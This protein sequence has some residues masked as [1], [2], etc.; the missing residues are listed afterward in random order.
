[1]RRYA[2]DPFQIA[3]CIMGFYVPYCAVNFSRY[4]VEILIELNAKSSIGPPKLG[5]FHI[6]VRNTNMF[7]KS[8]QSTWELLL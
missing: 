5:R 7:V 3:S 8:I 2:L 1:M 6:A 4:H